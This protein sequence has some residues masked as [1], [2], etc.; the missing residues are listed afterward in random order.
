MPLQYNFG[1]TN[2]ILSLKTITKSLNSLPL[3]DNS[4]LSY[5]SNGKTAD[6]ISNSSLVPDDGH[7]N[8]DHLYNNVVEVE[9]EHKNGLLNQKSDIENENTTNNDQF[10]NR[11]LNYVLLNEIQTLSGEKGDLGKE[12]FYIGYF[13]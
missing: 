2:E 4:K 13:L 3:E 5:L 12:L 8:E 6:L 7:D 11:M 1:D 10:S 9:E